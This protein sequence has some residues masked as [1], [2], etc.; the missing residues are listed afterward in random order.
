ML[1]L[2]SCFFFFLFDLRLS[3]FAI[4]IFI[5]YDSHDE[6]F[7][8]KNGTRERE[9]FRTKISYYYREGELTQLAT[10]LIFRDVDLSCP[11]G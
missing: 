9:I 5:A 11:T 10:R 4:I 2:S 7:N 6:I 8:L 3:V 1:L